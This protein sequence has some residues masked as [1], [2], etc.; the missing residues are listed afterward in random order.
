MKEYEYS[1]KV[2]NIEPYI[3]YC[4]SEGYK[5]TSETLQTRTLYR[6]PNKTMARITTNENGNHKKT[7]LDFKDDNQ[8]HEILKISRETIPLEITNENKKA[9]D[10]ILDMLGYTK[11]K[12]LVR[13]RTVY[14]KENVTFEIDKYD[15]PEVMFVVAIE[16]EENAVNKTTKDI[17][18]RLHKS[19]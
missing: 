17:Y 5:K 19:T 16:G 18:N 1:F 15:L 12:V 11:D 2:K 8:S 10:S 13:K 14:K 9:I 4:I 7:V 3:D 6:N